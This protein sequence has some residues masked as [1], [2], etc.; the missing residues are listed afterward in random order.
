MQRDRM[1]SMRISKNELKTREAYAEKWKDDKTVDVCN[2]MRYAYLKSKGRAANHDRNEQQSRE[3]YATDQV[4]ERAEYL[5]QDAVHYGKKT[6]QNIAANRKAQ[7]HRAIGGSV[8]FSNQSMYRG[9]GTTVGDG[10]KPGAMPIKTAENHAKSTGNTVAAFSDEMRA[11]MIHRAQMQRAARRAKTTS[12]A[13]QRTAR[14]AA[15]GVEEFFLSAIRSL[16]RVAQTTTQLTT[17]LITGGWIAMMAIVMVLMVGLIAGSSYGIFF[18]SEEFGNGYVMKDVIKEINHSYQRE[19]DTIQATVAHDEVEISGGTAR[20][21]E[22]LAIYAVKVTSDPDHGQEVATIDDEKKA[23]LEEMFWQMN[24]I[25]YQVELRTEM[26]VTENNDGYGNIIETWVPIERKYLKINVEHKTAEEMV[27]QLGFNRRQIDEVRQLIDEEQGSLW[28]TL[29]YGVGA[30]GNNIVE[31]AAS[32]IGNVGGQPYWSWYGF[33]SRVEWCACFV[34]WCAN[35]CGYI[36][37]GVIP[38]F[39]G[40]EHGVYW[41]KQRGQWMSGREEPSPGSIIFFDW[42]SNGQ[43]RAAD[44]VGIVARV[45][46]GRVYTIEGNTSDSCLERSYP[47][48]YKEILG[49]GV[50]AY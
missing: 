28:S 11:Q 1:I 38:R 37:T 19:L 15:S 42:V 21:P 44:H 13:A 30:G 41:F 46:N 18:S 9:T 10:L 5:A 20:W 45:E 29:L 31:V 48:G 22:V 7:S 49:Y 39:A 35:E 6:V 8:P 17:A 27:V 26:E 16:K 4:T 50:P 47:I 36:D 43:N 33:T 25:T 40:C 32:Q 12:E 2:R 23:F 24:C 14:M 34:S 3:E